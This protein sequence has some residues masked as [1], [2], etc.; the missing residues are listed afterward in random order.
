MN[1]NNFSEKLKVTI[2]A[3][4]NYA[5]ENNLNFFLPVHIL[6]ILL[7]DDNLI[8]KTLR[9]LKVNQQ[10]L[11]NESIRV[12]NEQNPSAKEIREWEES[13]KSHTDTQAGG[14]Q[15]RTAA[16]LSRYK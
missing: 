8:S 16:W 6:I 4:F 14:L 2:D 1:L 10:A 11:L 5:K 12:S 9:E 15:P 7:Q 3:S 13:F